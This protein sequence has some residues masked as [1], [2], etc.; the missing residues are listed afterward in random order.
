MSNFGK[1][2]INCWEYQYT[3]DKARKFNGTP[4]EIQLEILNK[5]YPIGMKCVKYD[6]FFKKYGDTRYEIV[7]YDKIETETIYQLKLIKFLNINGEVYQES[8]T[9]HPIHFK[10]TDEPFKMMNRENKLNDLGI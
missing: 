4:I 9:T 8:L 5:W 6:R 2:S 10:P 7:G 1:K 3:E